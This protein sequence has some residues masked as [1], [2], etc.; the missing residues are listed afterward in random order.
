MLRRNSASSN[1]A[2]ASIGSRFHQKGYTKLRLKQPKKSL[3]GKLPSW[4]GSFLL[5]RQIAGEN[6]GL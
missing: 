4:R 3:E 2:H 6:M 1:V 5:E